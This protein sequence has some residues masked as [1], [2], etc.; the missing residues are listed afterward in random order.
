MYTEENILWFSKVNFDRLSL[1]V[2]ILQS[3]KDIYI[4]YLLTQLGF[5]DGSDGKESACK[6]G[7]LGLFPESG[8][9]SG[10]GNGNPLQYSSLENF[11]DRGAWQAT[12]HE[13]QRVRHL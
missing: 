11:M 5:P 4:A 12:V 3:T 13:L 7:D 10:E 1:N 9:S 6:A 8:R 2:C